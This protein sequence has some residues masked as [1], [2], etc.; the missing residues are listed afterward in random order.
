[1]EA[2]VGSESVIRDELLG[3]LQ[4]RRCQRSGGLLV[5]PC[6]VEEAHACGE[7]PYVMAAAWRGSALAISEWLARSGVRWDGCRARVEGSPKGWRASE[8]CNG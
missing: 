2:V 8:V 5:R 6:V 1:M 4:Q 3:R 7:P